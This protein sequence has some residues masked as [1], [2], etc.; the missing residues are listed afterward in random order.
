MMVTLLG[1]VQ[2]G[3]AL[4]ISGSARRVVRMNEWQDTLSAS[5]NILYAVLVCRAPTLVECHN[6]E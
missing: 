2:A 3:A 6:L 1:H 4:R 5:E